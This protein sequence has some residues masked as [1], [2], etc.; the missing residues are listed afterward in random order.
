[1]RLDHTVLKVTDPERSAE[2]YR[3]VL[4]AEVVGLSWE[5]TAFVIGDARLHVHG[6]ASTP[7]PRP[8]NP[9]GPGSGDYCLEWPGSAA[10]AVAHLASCGVDVIAGPVPREAAKGTGQSVY[11]HDPDGNLLELISYA[12]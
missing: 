8:A 9:A 12:G 5:R 4:G 7:N 11:F 1:V 3:R 10:D 6:P 2:W